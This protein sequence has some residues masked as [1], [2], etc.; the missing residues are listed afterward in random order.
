[1]ESFNKQGSQLHPEIL[2]NKATG[3]LSIKGKSIPL[4]ADKFLVDVISWIEQY[5]KEPQENTNLEIDLTYM[6]GNSVRSLLGILY[7]MKA[8]SDTGKFVKIHWSVPSDAD[9]II[10]LSEGI[11]SKKN[12]PYD[13]SLN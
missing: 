6:N 5:S 9:D 10:E 4:N 12:L 3:Q 2:F 8:I 13:I 1:M 7:Q 11:L